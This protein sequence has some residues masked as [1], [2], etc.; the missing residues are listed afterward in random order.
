MLGAQ[1]INPNIKVKI[2][3]VNTWFDPGKEADAAKA[4]LDQG[5]DV[6]MQHTDSPAATQAAAKANAFAF[7]Q[8][9]DMI[10]FGPKSQLTA[11]VDNWVPCIY[12]ERVKAELAGKWTSTDTWGGLKSKL[13]VMAPYTNCPM[14]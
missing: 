14:T 1:S 2:I 9:F 8:D 12:D 11:I 5:A 13:V 10:K 3:W 4:L 7:G 6:V